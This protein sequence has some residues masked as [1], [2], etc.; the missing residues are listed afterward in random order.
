MP[1]VSD[2]EG[3]CQAQ[4]SAM[5]YDQLFLVVLDILSATLNTS[6]AVRLCDHSPPALSLNQTR[7]TFGVII[8]PGDRR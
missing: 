2:H 1:S 6:D 4:V 5:A 8:Q 7:R 3:P